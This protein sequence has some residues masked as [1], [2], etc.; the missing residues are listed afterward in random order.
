MKGLLVLNGGRTVLPRPVGLPG[1]TALCAAFYTS[2]KTS[3]RPTR[4]L[5]SPC[6][7]GWSRPY[8][9]TRRRSMSDKPKPDKPDKPDHP[10]HPPHPPH[11]GDKPKPDKG[12]TYG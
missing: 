11:P 10:V 7:Q 3:F 5:K 1:A 2:S 8:V 6:G 4:L 12:R 9:P